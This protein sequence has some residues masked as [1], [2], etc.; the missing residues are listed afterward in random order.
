[1]HC[2]KAYE[3]KYDLIKHKSSKDKQGIY[4]IQKKKKKKIERD[5]ERS[6]E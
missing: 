2:K 1:M 4:K 3:Q 6:E 5:R